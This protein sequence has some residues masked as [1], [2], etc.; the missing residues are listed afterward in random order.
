M[1]VLFVTGLTGFGI[2]GAR[3]EE[4]RLV[5]G[6]ADKGLAVAMCSDVL[7]GELVGI[8]HYR[9]DYPPGEN[10]PGSLPRRWRVLSLI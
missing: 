2:G 7:A 8:T 4:I 3:T 5:R 1:K 6:S 9:L 10:A